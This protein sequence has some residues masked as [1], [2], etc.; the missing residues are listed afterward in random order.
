MSAIQRTGALAIRA[1]FVLGALVA[2][3]GVALGWAVAHAYTAEDV[4]YTDVSV[5]VVTEYHDTGPSNRT[6]ALGAD[7]AISCWGI[8]TDDTPMDAPA[9][10]YTAVSAGFRHSCALRETGSITCWGANG[11]GQSN[12]PMGRYAEVSA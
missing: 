8:T 1:A 10:R 12:A 7:H 4:G 6:C 2:F 11:T 5:A 3:G 9:G